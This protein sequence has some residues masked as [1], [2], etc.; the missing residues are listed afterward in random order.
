MVYMNKNVNLSSDNFASNVLKLDIT[1]FQYLTI[2][3]V[4]HF[5]LVPSQNFLYSELHPLPLICLFHLRGETLSF[6]YNPSLG[7]SSCSYNRK[8][9]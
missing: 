8:T 6:L 4:K 3:M 9:S 5:L 2:F 1:L 7:A